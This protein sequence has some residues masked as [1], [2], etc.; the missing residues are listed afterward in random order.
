MS[1]PAQHIARRTLDLFVDRGLGFGD[2]T[3]DIAAAY[4]GTNDRPVL[5]VLTLDFVGS[6]LLGD[7]GEIFER[8][9][10]IPADR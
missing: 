6:F 8:N 4:V 10:P 3:G 2:E 7:L 9:R 5:H 1:T